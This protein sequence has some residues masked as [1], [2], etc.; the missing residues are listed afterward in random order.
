M[1]SNLKQLHDH[2]HFFISQGTAND[3]L[4][5]NIFYISVSPKALPIFAQ[6]IHQITKFNRKIYDGKEKVLEKT[7][8]KFTILIEPSSRVQLDKANNNKKK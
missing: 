8:I 4:F 3:F 1:Y 2:V 7:K 6:L 5:R